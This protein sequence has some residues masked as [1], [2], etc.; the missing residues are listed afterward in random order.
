MTKNPPTRISVPSEGCSIGFG[1]VSGLVNSP[2]C[3]APTC[4]DDLRQ[5]TNEQDLK[6][7][8]HFVSTCLLNHGMELM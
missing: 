1:N 8:Y 4:Y 2:E 6:E 3:T 7:V 5:D